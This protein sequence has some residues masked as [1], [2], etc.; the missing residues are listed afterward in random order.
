VPGTG[1][2]QQCVW[3][4]AWMPDGRQA[5]DV[6]VGTRLMGVDPETMERLSLLVSY[7]KRAMAECYLLRCANGVELT[8]SDSAPI[9]TPDGLVLAPDMLGKKT[10]TQTVV[11]EWSE[12]VAVIFV[13]RMPVQHITAENGNFFAGNVRG[14]YMAHHNIKWPPEDLY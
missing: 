7:S 5:K 12:V 1:G 2:G 14:K 6:T 13:G 8:C 4:N 9:P 3:A 10:I 11:R